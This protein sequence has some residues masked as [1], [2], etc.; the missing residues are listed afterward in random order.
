[1]SRNLLYPCLYSLL[2]EILPTLLPCLNH[3]C[4][5]L[6]CT[7]FCDFAF[8]PGPARFYWIKI[9]RIAWSE[10]LLNIVYII[11]S[12]LNIVIMSRGLI[13]LNNYTWVFFFTLFSEGKELWNENLL[14]ISI[15]ID[16]AAQATGEFVRFLI[17]FSCRFDIRELSKIEPS[18]IIFYFSFLL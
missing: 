17:P 5:A 3:L 7:L 9:W 12:V 10:H 11:Y 16:A 13:L 1:M 15:S 4:S 2:W 18:H 8:H 6:W 14:L